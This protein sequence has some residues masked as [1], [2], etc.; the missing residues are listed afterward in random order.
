MTGNQK[1]FLEDCQIEFDYVVVPVIKTED[2]P[3][4]TACLCVT[5]GYGEVA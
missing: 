3:V 2:E 4:H 5:V 1:A